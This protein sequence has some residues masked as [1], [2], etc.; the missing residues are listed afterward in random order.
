MISVGKHITVFEH[1]IIRYDKGEKRISEEQY[2]A[3][4][5]YYGNGVP[6]FSPCYNGV[7]FNEHVGVIQVGKTLIEVLPKAD[8]NPASED[9]ENRWRDI[10]INMLRAVGIFE[11]KATSDSS[12]K[13]K[14]NTI[15]DLYFEIFLKEIE[16][17]L[18]LGLIKK[19]RRK[20]GNVTALKGSLMFS[21]HIQQNLTHQERFYVRHT[22]YDTQHQLHYILYK[23]ICLLKKINTNA[24][25]HS[26]IG[27]ILLHFPEM[28]DIN[29]S[30]ATFEKIFFNRKTQSYKKSITIAKQ[31]LLQ[32]HPDLQRGRNDILALM[33]DMNRLWEKFVYVSLRNSGMNVTRTFTDF[34]E[35]DTGLT[36]RL[37]PDILINEETEDC[38]VL[39]T[40]W[41]I[42][43]DLKPA[44]H[45]LRQMYAYN[46]YF[47][48]KKSALVYPGNS[49]DNVNGNFYRTPHNGT[50]N[51]KC[52]LLFL[53][54]PTKG[55][56]NQSLVRTWQG[57][58]HSDIKKWSNTNPE[59]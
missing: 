35:P 42:L 32:F 46:E 19:Y 59:K 48:A 38:V 14:P 31:L 39:D 13:T 52:G 47:A 6:Y 30:A 10:L 53:E 2:K 28:P 27:A 25:L 21:K 51:K 24:A 12:L 58:I 23:A 57:K 9:E 36:V 1:E 43:K 56:D 4:L 20:E 34:W 15:L 7:Q 54:L 44:I 18:H 22:T 3:L 37:K 45:D 29:V 40:K 33:F 8:K 11:I 55:E 50:A 26:R 5:K 41:K 16:Y 17:L 49:E